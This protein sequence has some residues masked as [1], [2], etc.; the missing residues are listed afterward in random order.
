MIMLGR[1]FYPTLKFLRSKKRSIEFSA[2]KYPRLLPIAQMSNALI[3][4]NISE[5]GKP[6]YIN[7]GLG[8]NTRG[9]ISGGVVCY[10]FRKLR[11]VI[12]DYKKL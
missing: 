6:Q 7:S 1:R 8:G 5:L 3:G 9:P 4:R 12:Q 10:N 11:H 2:Q